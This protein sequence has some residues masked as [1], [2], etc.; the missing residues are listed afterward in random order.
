MLHQVPHL[1]S[2]ELQHF[3]NCIYFFSTFQPLCCISALSSTVP[4]LVCPLTKA[5]GFSFEPTLSLYQVKFSLHTCVSPHASSRDKAEP[6]L[7]FDKESLY[8][9]LAINRRSQFCPRVPIFPKPS[10]W[11]GAIPNCQARTCKTSFLSGP[12]WQ[13]F[14]PSWNRAN[15]ISST[16]SFCIF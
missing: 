8:Q 5:E 7:S 9:D 10:S 15:Q 13:G 11:L 4:K 6:N 3:P 14:I 16:L 12:P 2:S 1:L